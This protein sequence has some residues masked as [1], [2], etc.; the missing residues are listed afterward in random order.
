[1]GVQRCVGLA[2]AA[3]ALAVSS[4][5]A[6]PKSGDPAPP[7]YLRGSDDKMYRLADYR[8]KQAVVLAWFAKAFTSG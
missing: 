6:E 2:I 1:M 5:G 3:C 4:F 8:G 7:F